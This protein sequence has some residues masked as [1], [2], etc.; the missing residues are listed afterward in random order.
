MIGLSNGLVPIGKVVINSL[1]P[2]GMSE[3]LNLTAFLGT[4][5]S[6]VHIVH[7]S[8]VIIAFKG[9]IFKYISVTSCWA[10]SVLLP[11]GEWC[12]TLTM[13][14]ESVIDSL[15]QTSDTT[16]CKSTL[17][18]VMAWFYLATSH[19]LNQCWS[20]S[21]TLYGINMPQWLKT[22]NTW[23]VVSWLEVCLNTEPHRTTY[24]PWFV[25]RLLRTGVQFCGCR[26]HLVR[27]EKTHRFSVSPPENGSSE[28]L[29][30]CPDM[31]NPFL[32]LTNQTQGRV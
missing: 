13:I 15:C 8:C 25:E 14:S 19:H 20:R 10:F 7:I 3:W 5:D 23:T 16:D 31:E 4:A 12:R 18:H 26:H 17:V 27:L 6:E 32:L 2:I 9:K 29:G 21:P 1:S 28:L 22:F 30:S 11:L 24:S